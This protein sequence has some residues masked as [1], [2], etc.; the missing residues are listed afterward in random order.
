MV[1]KLK[2]MLADCYIWSFLEQR[3]TL[4]KYL[5][6]YNALALHKHS[7][8]SKNLVK[9]LNSMLWS[10]ENSSSRSLARAAS[11]TSPTHNGSQLKI[12]LCCIGVYT[13]PHTCMMID[14]KSAVFMRSSFCV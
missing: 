1:L 11:S 7:M 8:V 12:K 14:L 9:T 2:E 13:Y 4:C 5:R 10:T 3:S 6:H